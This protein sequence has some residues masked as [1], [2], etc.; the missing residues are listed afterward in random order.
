VADEPNAPA[1]RP[2]YGRR[3]DQ[4]K[5]AVASL[6]DRS[7]RLSNYR[8]VAFVATIGTGIAGFTVAGVSPYL[9]GLPFV[10]FIA[11]VAVHDRVIRRRDR[12]SFAVTYY[13]RGLRRLDDEWEGDGTQTADYVGGEHPYAADLDLF[14]PGSLFELLCRARTRAGEERLASWLTGWSPAAD[15]R[16]RQAAA[17]DLAGKLDLREDLA[18]LGG[19][20]RVSIKPDTLTGWGESEPILH[21]ARATALRALA[22][23]LPSLVVASIVAW[24]VTDLGALPFVGASALVWVAS[25]PFKEE[26]GRTTIAV[27]EPGRELGVLVELFARLEREQFHNEQLEDLRKELAGAS[28]HIARLTRLLAW[29]EAQRNQVFAPIAFLLMWSAHFSLAIERWR[30]AVGRSIRAWL[31][32]LAELEALSSLAS[33]AYEHPDDAVPQIVDEGP[34]FE[35]EDLGHP[36]LPEGD[37]IRNS[38]SL[39]GQL[40]VLIVSGSNMSGKSTLLRTVGINLVLALAGCRARA[41]SLRVSPLAV[42]ATL[43]VQDSLRQG[44][45][46]FYAEVSRLKLLADISAGAPPLLFLLDEVFHGTNS[47]DRLI[48]A[49]A[50]IRSLIDAGSIGLVTTHDLAL[51]KAA[52]GLGERAR[53]VHFADEIRDGELHFDYRMHPGVVQKSN[54]LELMRSVG[55]SV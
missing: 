23:G 44:T 41:E 47:H 9:A 34:V 48:G 11:L 2:E 40:Q 22:W 13:E 21:G 6:D 10:A 52:D 5:S 12:A 43:R 20:V 50:V 4:R 25:R 15:V 36:L 16:R 18:L 29:L 28:A 38:V 19:D 35:G 54:A 53:N 8:V 39:G 24:A 31:D 33:Y 37:F 45:S 7:N 26:I 42:G 51:A 30:G 3:L 27:A 1:P 46:R 55:L 14:G 49:E 17:G 32:G